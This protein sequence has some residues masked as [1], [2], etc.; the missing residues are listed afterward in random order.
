MDEVLQTG[1]M[2]GE[3]RFPKKEKLRHRSLVEALFRE[4]E[5]LYAFPLRLV[6]KGFSGEELESL[7]C[8][9][10]PP[11]I[12][13]VQMMVTVAKKKRRRAVDRVLMRRRIREAYRLRKWTLTRRMEKD[14]EVSLLALSFLYMA[15]ENLPYTKVSEAIDTLL[16]KLSD[17]ISHR[18]SPTSK[19]GGES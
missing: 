2:K 10:L 1:D 5:S 19:N 11:R 15:T 7:F 14:A 17:K 8:K 9:G 12:G 6:Y 16:G 18:Q 3:F 4:G 13:K